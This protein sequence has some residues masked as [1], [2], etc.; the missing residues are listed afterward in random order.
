MSFSVLSCKKKHDDIYGMVKIHGTVRDDVS[1]APIPNATVQLVKIEKSFN[2][3]WYIYV[4][5]EVAAT[6]ATDSNGSYS[7]SY[8]AK[9]VY[10]LTLDAMPADSLHVPSNVDRATDGEHIKTA[11]EHEQNLRC[12]RS[13]WAKIILTN[14]APLVAPYAISISVSSLPGKDDITLNNFNGDTTVYLKLVGSLNH[15]NS[16]RFGT[17]EQVN[18]Y[19]E[20]IVAPWDTITMQL[21]Y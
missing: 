11:G 15:K 16:I 17:S 14:K 6:T 18:S 8:E 9:G 13:A 1:G 20:K 10:E 5:T 12:F 7:L 19:Y 4:E 3:F 21:S 2:G